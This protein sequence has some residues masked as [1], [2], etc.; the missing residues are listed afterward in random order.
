MLCLLGVISSA[1][2]QTE[3]PV[4]QAVE[5]QLVKEEAGVKVYFTRGMPCMNPNAI[6]LKFENT[7]TSDV[8][9]NWSLPESA[10]NIPMNNGVNTSIT[11]AT[12]STEEAK[13]SS[14]FPVQLTIITSNNAWVPESTMF[15]ITAIKK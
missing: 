5:W 10:K 7:S 2:S 4:E 6:A 9:V 1:F 14:L 11:V 3:K 8:Q 13:C 12:G 15:T